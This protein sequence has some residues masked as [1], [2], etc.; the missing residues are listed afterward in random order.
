MQAHPY[1]LVCPA[2]LLAVLILCLNHLGDGMRDALD[3]R[4]R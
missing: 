1:L 4:Q 2:L 3:P